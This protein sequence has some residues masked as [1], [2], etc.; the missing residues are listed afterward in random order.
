MTKPTINEM[1]KWLEGQTLVQ[2]NRGAAICDAIRD[3]L[4]EMKDA[5]VIQFSKQGKWVKVFSF[6]P[7]VSGGGGGGLSGY[8][9]STEKVPT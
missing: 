1:V 7:P 8:L 2:D 6:K 5:D 4:Q 3:L 9:T